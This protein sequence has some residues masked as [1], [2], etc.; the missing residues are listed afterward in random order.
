MKKTFL[1]LIVLAFVFSSCKKEN[2]AKSFKVKYTIGCTDCWVAYTSDQAG[3][4][5]NAYHQNSTWTY[6]FDGKE[7]QELLLLAY[8]TS[9]GHQAVTATI[10][11]N[12][13]VL[14]TR[15][16]YCPVNGVALCADTIR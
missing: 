9:S 8:N 4:Q 13:A 12:D 2:T 5:S 16:T 10:L 11:V 1:L 15:T 14:E 6:S 3:T 7:G